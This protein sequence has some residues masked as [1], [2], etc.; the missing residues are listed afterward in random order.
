MHRSPSFRSGE[1]FSRVV[2][3]LVLFVAVVGG[4]AWVTQYLPN[5][6]RSP[7][8]VEETPNAEPLLKFS[9]EQA[10]FDKDDPDY[11]QEIETNEE[12]HYDFA[13]EN[14]SGKELELGLQFKN[15]GCTQVE[16][17]VGYEPFKPMVPSDKDKDSQIVG[18][19]RAGWCV[20]TG[21][22]SKSGRTSGSGPACG[23]RTRAWP[24]LV[25]FRS[26]KPRSTSCRR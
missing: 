18:A 23:V 2:L 16:A 12:G 10:L 25:D 9:T 14:I 1:V 7:R 6:P 20:S 3:P 11:G 22:A 4:I 26:W 5:G 8:S 19:G 13:F 15:C 17:K 21:R 24:R